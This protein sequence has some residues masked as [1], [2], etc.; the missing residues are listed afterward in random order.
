MALPDLESLPI[1]GERQ[2]ARKV[3]PLKPPAF[4]VNN[5]AWL[6]ARL[7]TLTAAARSASN[8]ALD[9]LH[10]VIAASIPVT[11]NHRSMSS[12]P[13]LKAGSSR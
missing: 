5:T 3:A 10:V 11:E 8:V 1:I 4:A 6:A 7:P 12:P 2:V 13:A 9:G